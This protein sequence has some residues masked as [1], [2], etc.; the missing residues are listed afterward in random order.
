[1]N[2]KLLLPTLLLA[3][4]LAFAQSPGMPMHDHMMMHNEGGEHHGDMGH[5]GDHFMWWKNPEIAARI[6]LTPDQQKKMEDIFIQSRV[7]LID[8]HATIEKEQL[9]LEPLMNAN[10]VDQAKAI[11]QIDKVADSRAALE[12]TNAK[13]LLSIRGVLTPDQWTKLQAGRHEHE[14]HHGEGGPEGMHHGG[15]MGPGG[16]HWNHQPSGQPK[17]AAPATPPAQ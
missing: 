4:P 1:M 3:A 16:T 5:G 15:P 7:Q 11:A 12:K 17:P 8:L 13:M 10:P 2:A 14:M 6:G 9:L